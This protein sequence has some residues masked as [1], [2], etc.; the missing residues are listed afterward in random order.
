[1]QV[2]PFSQSLSSQSSM[3]VWQ[4][5]PSKPSGHVQLQ[6]H[7]ALITSSPR[8]LHE[9]NMI[10]I[11][12]CTGSKA[13]PPH[14]YTPSSSS[15]TWQVPPLAHGL[16]TQA[17]RAVSQ[18]LPWDGEQRRCSLFAMKYADLKTALH[19]QALTLNPGGQLHLYIST[20]SLW[21]MPWFRQ[22]L[23]RQGLHLASTAVSTSPMGKCQTD[24]IELHFDTSATSG[25]M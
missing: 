10:S 23:D 15:F 5:G 3:L 24:E 4:V 19:K 12:G 9:I 16:L 20:R 18:F 8:A 13:R 25:G 2:A 22:G 21:Q 1:M 11:H 7:A 17:F 14:L 6:Q